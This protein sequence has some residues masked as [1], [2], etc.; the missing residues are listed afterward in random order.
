MFNLCNKKNLGFGPNNIDWL[1]YLKLSAITVLVKSESLKST[2]SDMATLRRAGSWFLS[3]GRMTLEA[4]AAHLALTP[5]KGDLRTVPVVGV[6]THCETNPQPLGRLRSLKS[7]NFTRSSVDI[8]W[9]Q[10]VG[11]FQHFHN[12]GKLSANSFLYMMMTWKHRHCFILR[13]I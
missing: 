7:R 5:E 8:V 10:G 13:K 11:H 6:R 4:G 12:W 1:T 3:Q 9:G 2:K